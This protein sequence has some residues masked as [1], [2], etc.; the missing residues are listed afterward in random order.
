MNRRSFIQS[1]AGIAAAA[2]AAHV[3]A[4]S[5]SGRRKRVAMIVTEVRKMSHG[6]HFVDRLLGGYGWQGSHHH[7]E[8]DLVSMYV[9]Q[10]PAGDLSRE[11]EQRFWCRIYP[12]VEEALTL[13]TGKLAVDGVV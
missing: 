1:T 6:Q 10:F 7:P 2:A 4:S 13:G 9:D 5:K 12:T 8:V 11:R 3:Q